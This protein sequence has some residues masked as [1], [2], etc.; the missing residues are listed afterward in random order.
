MTAR[1]YIRRGVRNC[2]QKSIVRRGVI[3]R[4]VVALDEHSWWASVV[5][6]G[7]RKQLIGDACCVQ[8]PRAS[9]DNSV[10]LSLRFVEL[11]PLWVDPGLHLAESSPELVEPRLNMVEPAQAWSNLAQRSSPAH[12]S[13]PNRA[14][15]GRA[16]QDRSNQA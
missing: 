15:P 16:G 10:E 6:S 12:I 13:E 2:P 14:G 4:A 1:S 5:I 3:K 11:G 9:S 7:L 8:R